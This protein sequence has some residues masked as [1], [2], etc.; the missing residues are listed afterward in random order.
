MH[1]ITHFRIFWDSNG[2]SSWDGAWWR[3]M[4]SYRDRF[5]A[6]AGALLLRK[7]L[8]SAMEDR[9]YGIIQML[10]LQGQQNLQASACWSQHKSVTDSS[11]FTWCVLLCVILYW[12]VYRRFFRGN[13]SKWFAKHSLCK[14]F[15]FTYG[16]NRLLPACNHQYTEQNNGMRRNQR[17]IFRGDAF[18]LCGRWLF[19]NPAIGGH[20]GGECSPYSDCCGILSCAT[21]GIFQGSLYS[22]QD[23]T[24]WQDMTSIS[25]L[26]VVDILKM[27]LCFFFRSL[28]NLS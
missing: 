7:D 16:F 20:Q 23:T 1:V 11:D 22:W 28:Q 4:N 17:L 9:T 12:F 15:Y 25:N 8:S 24:I 2:W 6:P 27:F 18:A 21:A 19:L 14:C 3:H 5:H 13:R 10:S 26:D